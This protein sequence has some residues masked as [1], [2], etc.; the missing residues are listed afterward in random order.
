MTWRSRDLGD[1]TG[2]TVVVTGANSGIGFAAARGLVD[3]GAHVVLA[4]RDVAKGEE[5]AARLGGAGSTSI[6]E[7]DLSDLDQV[8]GCAGTLLDRHDALSALV[9]NAGVMGGPCRHTGHGHERQMATNHLGHAAL[10]AALWPLLHAGSAR[11]VVMSSTEARRGRLSARTTREE[12]LD[13]APYDGRQVYRNT[14]QANLLFALELHRRCHRCGSPVSAVAVHPGASATNLFAR[15]L[16]QAGRGRLA[17]ASKVASGA[18]LQSA[19]AGARSTLRALD[20]ATPGG[21]FVGPARFGQLRG[22][23]E[24]LDVYPS[25]ADPATA[26]RLWELTAAVVAPLTPHARPAPVNRC[27]SRP[28]S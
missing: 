28:R 5:A 1:Q 2:H 22:P 6:A 3:R 7:L 12:L 27:A 26:A 4:V 16:E 10:V 24:L 19:A 14:K 25:A 18:V 15:Q 8:T 13:P 9:C 23:P 17:A 11:V 20:P 21:A